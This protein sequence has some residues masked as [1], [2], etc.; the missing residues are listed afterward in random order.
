M[1]DVKLGVRVGLRKG[2][3]LGFELSRFHMIIIRMISVFCSFFL[4]TSVPAA[5]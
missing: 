1:V 3:F 4:F 2:V 5:P